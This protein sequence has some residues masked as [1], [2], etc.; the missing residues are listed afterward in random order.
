[1]SCRSAALPCAFLLPAAAVSWE[2]T[3]VASLLSALWPPWFPATPA[4]S[5]LYWHVGV[6][7]RGLFLWPF[8]LLL[9]YLT[10]SLFPLLNH[11]WVSGAH[12]EVQV[13]EVLG[14]HCLV[15]LV[16]VV[17]PTAAP[18]CLVGSGALHCHRGRFIS[19]CWHGFIVSCLGSIFLGAVPGPWAACQLSGPGIMPLCDVAPLYCCSGPGLSLNQLARLGLVHGPLVV[20]VQMGATLIVSSFYMARFSALACLITSEVFCTVCCVIQWP[21]ILR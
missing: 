3:G 15:D 13:G 14:I 9:F 20:P 2:R 4:G 7:V 21:A 16:V 6:W 1:M 18:C 5:P 17:A 12:S 8:E 19:F 11:C 10:A